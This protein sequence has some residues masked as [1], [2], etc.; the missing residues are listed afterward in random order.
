MLEPAFGKHICHECRGNRPN[1]GQGNAGLVASSQLQMTF[2]TGLHLDRVP[3]SNGC[4]GHWFFSHYPE[5]KGIPGR[6]LCY[7]VYDGA[8]MVGIIGAN[9]PP[10]NY[11]IFRA[12]FQT[13]NDNTFVSNNVF[14]L[15]TSRQNLASRVLKYFRY[16]VRADYKLQYGDDLLGIVTFVEP[17]R[18]GICYQADNWSLLGMTQGKRM[19]RDKE[20]WQKVFSEGTSKYIYGFKYRQ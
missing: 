6:S 14:R 15:I 16:R 1:K 2:E 7:L 9:S 8:E 19:R 5:S 10:C 20:T 3:K 17:P 18:T 4:F 12:Y 13:D 11:K